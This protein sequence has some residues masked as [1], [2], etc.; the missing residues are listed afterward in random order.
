MKNISLIK[1]FKSIFSHSG[2]SKIKIT[3]R[4]I[5]LLFYKLIKK[6]FVKINFFNSK[7]ILDLHTPGISKTLLLYEKR[8]LL[9]TDIIISE[10]KDNMNILDIGANIGYYA[11]IEASLIN[12][13]IIYAF[14]PDHRN[15]EILKKNIELNNFSDKIILFPYAVGDKNCSKKFFL[16]KE[17]NL[18]SFLNNNKNIN[19]VFVKCIKLDNFKDIDKIDFIRM[20]I[21]GYECM[22]IDGMMYFLRNTKKPLKLMIEV[23]PYL[24]T[25]IKYNF[26]KR[27]HL[28]S[29]F[30]FY[31]KYLVSA[32]VAKPQKI[33]DS[34]YKPIKTIKEG[35]L[36]RG[37]YADIKIEHLLKF[38]NSETKI[39]RAIFLEKKV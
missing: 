27:L 13:G 15:I 3:F 14:E 4:I 32:G 24:Y 37:L 16:S 21:E 31:V 22:A 33:I 36:Q 35:S 6:R 20:D 2:V 11:I 29:N 23:H 9:E 30:G 26:C 38:L 12:N 19:S 25:K 39:V 17:T 8:E 7:M 18:S 10:I 28:L 5:K 34:G 1:K